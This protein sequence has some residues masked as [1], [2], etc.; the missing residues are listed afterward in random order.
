MD[1]PTKTR[2]YSSFDLPEDTSIITKFEES[3]TQQHFAEEV[4][5]NK[6]M[7]RYNKTGVVDVPELK[8]MFADVSDEVEY[9]AYKN[10]MIHAEE[11]FMKLPAALRR[12]FDDDPAD[13]LMFLDDENNRKEAIELGLIAA[14]PAP[15][16]DIKPV[17]E[18][19]SPI[20]D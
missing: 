9:Y 6:I 13:L 1:Q 5:I 11:E 2:I 18:P 17:V 4:D 3:K 8:G 10:A 15:A 20:V 19:P 16:S 12:R 14:D 7:E